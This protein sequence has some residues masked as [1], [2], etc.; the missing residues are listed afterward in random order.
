VQKPELKKIAKTPPL[1]GTLEAAAI[2]S[3][4]WGRR[5]GSPKTAN[6]LGAKIK[7]IEDDGEMSAVGLGD[8]NGVLVVTV[9]EQ[10]KAAQIGLKENDVIRAVNAQQIKDLSAFAGV[11]QSEASAGP[12]TL[13]LWRDQSPVKLDAGR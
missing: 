3:G 9:P 10:S 4:G 11:Y 13:E 8:K 5:Y 1:P 7:N 6:W 12:V 2:R